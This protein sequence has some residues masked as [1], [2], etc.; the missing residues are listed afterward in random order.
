MRTV[1]RAL[2]VDQR[3]VSLKITRGPFFP[4][5]AN[6]SHKT[7]YLYTLCEYNPI[8]GAMRALIVD[9]DQDLLDVMTYSL[10]RDGYEVIAA[11]TGSRRSIACASTG[12][13]SWS[14][15]CS[16]AASMGSR[17]AAGC[18]CSPRCR[19]SSIVVEPRGAGRAARA[20]TGRR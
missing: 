9:E 15:T 8:G 2:A 12:R 16:S 10:R 5:Q 18:A 17:S 19:S 13:T 14:S 7:Y 11:T 3:H 1:F 6:S 20:P 4:K